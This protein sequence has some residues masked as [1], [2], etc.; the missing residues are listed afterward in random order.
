MKPFIRRVWFLGAVGSLLLAP[1][2]AQAGPGSGHAWHPGYQVP[3]PHVQPASRGGPPPWSPP[4]HVYRQGYGAGYQDGYR[5]GYRDARVQQKRPSNYRGHYHHPPP[6]P[7][8][9]V[10]HRDAGGRVDVNVNYR[11]RF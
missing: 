6:P 10:H 11:Y 7:P 3:P 5:Q 8:R 4:A 1:M 9:P 2:A